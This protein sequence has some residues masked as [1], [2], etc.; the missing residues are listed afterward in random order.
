MKCVVLCYQINELFSQSIADEKHDGKP[1]ADN[2]KN[3]WEDE[4]QISS[5][6]LS[7]EELKDESY[8]LKGSYANGEDFQFEILAMRLIKIVS[9]NAP[10]CFVGASE[11]IIEKIQISKNTEQ[12]ILKLFLK[13]LEPFANPIPGIYI[14]TKE[15]PKELS[16]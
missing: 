8:Q 6:V 15:F 12:F 3:H 11:S 7:V 4:L 5:S 16:S 2:V 14:S 10:V 9:E 13:D 1:S